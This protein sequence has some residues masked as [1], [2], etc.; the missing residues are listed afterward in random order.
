MKGP[1][2]YDAGDLGAIRQMSRSEPRP[3]E[4]GR[5]RPY[6]R[7]TVRTERILERNLIGDC[8][9]VPGVFACFDG[10]RPQTS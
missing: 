2:W 5:K 6:R 9:K 4:P 7:P 3:P 10:G 8:L 1:A